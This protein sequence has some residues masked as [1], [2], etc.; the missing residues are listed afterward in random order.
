MPLVKSASDKAVGENVQRLR[1]EK[2]PRRQAVAIALD[3]QRRAGGGTK[4]KG[5]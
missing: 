5:T 3:V 1:A 2:K 4:K